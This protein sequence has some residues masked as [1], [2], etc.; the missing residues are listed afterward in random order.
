M[1][2]FQTF[3]H[4]MEKDVLDGVKYFFGARNLLKELNSTFIVLIP[5]FVGAEAM[6]CFHPIS[7]CNSFYKTISKVLTLRL[8]SIFPAIISPQ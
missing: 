3:W 8:L 6:D 5:M 2:F 7:L 1:F 4:V